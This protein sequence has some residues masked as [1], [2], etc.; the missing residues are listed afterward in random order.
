MF[1]Y[2]NFDVPYTGELV[3]VK[4]KY[5]YSPSGNRIHFTKP[6]QSAFALK[7]DKQKLLKDIA[8]EC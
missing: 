4:N 3:E 5:Y 6:D 1:T 8:G 7:F 2:S